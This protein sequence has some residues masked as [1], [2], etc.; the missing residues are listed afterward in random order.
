M[1]RTY[2]GHGRRASGKFTI[3]IN[4]LS[5]E[6]LHIKNITVCLNK[7]KTYHRRQK[8]RFTSISKRTEVNNQRRILEARTELD[9]TKKMIH[10]SL[11]SIGTMECLLIKCKTTSQSLATT[12]EGSTILEESLQMGALNRLFYRQFHGGM[13]SIRVPSSQITLDSIKGTQHKRKWWGST[14]P[15][16]RIW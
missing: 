5:C 15:G 4:C 1:T 12:T 13:F 16:K 2:Q 8:R 6:S 3:K 14:M 11:H 9:T 7:R 10:N